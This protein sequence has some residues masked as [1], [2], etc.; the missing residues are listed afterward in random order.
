[1]NRSTHA[2]I[3]AHTRWS[4]CDD[5]AEATRPGRTAFM[6]RFYDQVDPDGSLS[7]AE[8][9]RRAHNALKAHMS[10]LAAKRWAS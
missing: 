8:A 6:Q 10:R 5:R 2:R 1:M 7:P 9:D 4:Q 3:A